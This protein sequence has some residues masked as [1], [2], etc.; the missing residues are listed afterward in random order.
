[1]A[2]MSRIVLSFNFLTKK[3]VLILGVYYNRLV[4]VDT[5]L[6]TMN[7]IEKT[8]RENNFCHTEMKSIR[9]YPE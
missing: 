1:M 5:F 8:G 9:R 4:I 2:Y 3:L 7:K 6:S